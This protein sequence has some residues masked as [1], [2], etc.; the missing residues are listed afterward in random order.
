MA[1]KRRARER[2]QD[3]RGKGDGEGGDG[4]LIRAQRGDAELDQRARAS[5]AGHHA[6]AQAP[7]GDGDGG[8]DIPFIY[9]V[10]QRSSSVSSPTRSPSLSH[11]AATRDGHAQWERREGEGERGEGR[12]EME[13]GRWEMGDEPGD[14]E[15]DP[16]NGRICRI[17]CIGHQVTSLVIIRLNKQ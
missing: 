13:D 9:G 15:Q 11:P 14:G 4:V 12:G 10:T 5:R 2:A 17:C 7:D 16:E 8:K 6:V 1:A 3:S